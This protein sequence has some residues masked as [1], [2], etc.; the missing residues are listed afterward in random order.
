MSEASTES[1]ESESKGA[2]LF[3]PGDGLWR[4]GQVVALPPRAIGGP[5]GASMH[6]STARIL[7]SSG[8]SLR[9]SKSC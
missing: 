8:I 2:F 5:G 6:A 1:V 9:A 4:D 7:M 3:V